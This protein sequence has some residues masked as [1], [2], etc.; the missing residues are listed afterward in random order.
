MKIF[1]QNKKVFFE[2]EIEDTFEAGIVL[3][4]NEV[5]SIRNNQINL[6][7][8]Y[9]LFSDNEFFLINC[10]ISKYKNSFK[11]NSEKED[12][13]KK[14]LLN[15]KE[16]EKLS[17]KVSRKGVTILPLKVYENEKGY[18]KI[19]I[20]VGKHKKL[21]DKKQELKEKDLDRE[22]KREIRGK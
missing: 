13:N 5:K 19:L 16:I 11:D 2:Y 4:G 7:A 9:V 14:L 20:G 8:S 3:N 21:H 10:K 22:A 17:G 6:T 18:I 15:R 12:R 1:A